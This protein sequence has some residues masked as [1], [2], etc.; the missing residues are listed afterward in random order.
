MWLLL[1]VGCPKP[2]GGEGEGGFVYEEGLRLVHDGAFGFGDADG[3]GDVD[4][5]YTGV[6]EGSGIPETTWLLVNEGGAL[7]ETDAGITGLSEASFGFGHLDSDGVLDVASV[8]FDGYAESAKVWRGQGGSF[9]EAGSLSPCTYG[10]ALWGDADN[11]GDLDLHITGMQGSIGLNEVYWNQGGDL[12]DGNAGMQM[13]SASNSG[14]ADWDGDRDLDLAVCGIPG[15]TALYRNDGGVFV[16]Q[17]VLPGAIGCSLSFGDFDLDG[18]PDLAVAGTGDPDLANVF[19]NDG[20]GNFAD[21]GFG[22]QG[23]RAGQIAWGDY[24]GDGDPDLALQG[25]DGVTGE[26]YGFV[27][28]NEGTGFADAGVAMRGLSLGGLGWADLDGDGALELLQDR[29]SVV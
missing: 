2:N 10:D 28:R 29:K 18:D 12:V 27:Y 25:L 16:A 7:A 21:G 8:G 11:D 26:A 20:A 9:V 19:V 1:L 14:W 13:K 24:D 5:L 22:L 15:D 4:V 17:A 6:P 3:D 23:V